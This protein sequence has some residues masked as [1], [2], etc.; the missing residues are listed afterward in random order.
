[1]DPMTCIHTTE[2]LCP[3]CEEEYLEDPGAWLEFG[4]HQ[5]GIENWKRVQEEMA[6]DAELREMARPTPQDDDIPF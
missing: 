2:G 3:A 1:M 6:A 4:N 5:E